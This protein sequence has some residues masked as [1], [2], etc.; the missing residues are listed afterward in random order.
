MAFLTD[1][2]LEKLISGDRQDKDDSKLVLAPYCKKCMTPVG[3]DLRVGQTYITSNI[4]EVRRD[5]KKGEVITIPSN[6][7][8]L[9]S[10][11]EWIRMPKDKM[12]TGLIE[13]KVSM[14]SRGLSHISTTVDPDYRGELLIAVH[15]HSV[16]DILLEYG[17]RFCTI[18]FFKNATPATRDCEKQPGRLDIFLEEFQK[19]SAKGQQKRKT[20][21]WIPPSLVIIAAVSGYMVFGN[22]PG[23]IATVA[24]GVAISQFI[25]RRY[26]R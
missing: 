18:V 7:T 8:A 25:E 16:Q 4:P 11:L 15:N 24:I 22:A 5:L 13:S 20:K 21:D 9:I 26:L 3:Y 2:D 19:R 6:T 10:T 12:L 1:T 17:K 14:V 23:F